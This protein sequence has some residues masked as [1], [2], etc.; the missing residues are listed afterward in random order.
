MNKITDIVLCQ[1]EAIEYDIWAST[2]QIALPKIRRV[3]SRTIAK[4]LVSVQPMMSGPAMRIIM[5][6]EDFIIGSG[7]GKRE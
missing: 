1:K 7:S 6:S 2:L 5:E 3:Y 4:D